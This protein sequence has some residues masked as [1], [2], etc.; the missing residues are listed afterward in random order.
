MN[1]QSNQSNEH[2]ENILASE[3]LKIFKIE[4]TVYKKGDTICRNCKKENPQWIESAI[5]PWGTC[6]GCNIMWKLNK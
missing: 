1:N 6:R 3:L 5:D 4:K 2:I